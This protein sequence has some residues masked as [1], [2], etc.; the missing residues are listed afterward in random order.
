M[1]AGDGLVSIPQDKE[2]KK[3]T[4]PIDLPSNVAAQFQLESVGNVQATNA[5]ARNIATMATGVLQA[6]MARNF[7][8]MDT[9]E[10]RANS[11]VM[12]TPIA[13]PTTQVPTGP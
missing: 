8:Q 10:S 11:G 3:M 1:T 5:Q 13:G 2:A 12:A 9:I 4:D 6:A 7:D